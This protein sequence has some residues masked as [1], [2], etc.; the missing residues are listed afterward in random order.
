MS[1]IYSYTTVQPTSEDLLIGTDVGSEKATKS[2]TVGSIAA[3]AGEIASQGTLNSV[4]ISTTNGITAAGNPNGPAVAYTVGLQAGSAPSPETNYFLRGDNTWATPTVTA[5]IQVSNQGVQ[6]TNDVQGLNFAGDG[7]TATPTGNGNVEITIGGLTNTVNSVTAGIGIAATPSNG[8]GDVVIENTGV[9]SLQTGPGLSATVGGVG[10]TTGALLLS[11]TGSSSS[12]TVTSVSAGPGLRISQG[13]ITTSPTLAV[14]YIGTNNIIS[15][16]LSQATPLSTDQIIY[17]QISSGNVKTTTLGQV[18]INALPLVKTYIEDQEVGS[19][20]NTGDTF[21]TAIATNIVTLEQSEYTA[22]ATKLPNTLY[23]TTNTVIAPTETRLQIND[24]NITNNTGV[25]PIPIIIT[26][27]QAYPGTGSTKTGEPG[28]TITPAYNSTI[29]IDENLYQ[30]GG[31]VPSTM[32]NYV[33]VYPA[34][35]NS[36]QLVSSVASTAVLEL[37]TTAP[38]TSTLNTAFTNNFTLDGQPWN[39][40][41]AGLITPDWVQSPT[42]N[43]VITGNN[44]DP[45]DNSTQWGVNYTNNLTTQYSLTAGTDTVVYTPAQGTYDGAGVNV[46]LNGA[47]TTVNS[48]GVFVNIDDQINSNNGADRGTE[49]NILITPNPITGASSGYIVPAGT[50]TISV[51]VQH[52]PFLQVGTSVSFQCTAVGISPFTDTTAFA[53][54]DGGNSTSNISFTP[55]NINQGDIINTENRFTF[56]AAGA[57]SSTQAVSSITSVSFAGLTPNTACPECLTG[58]LPTGVSA[59]F[60]GEYST[61]NGTTWTSPW[62]GITPIP[63]TWSVTV[64]Q[65]TVVKWRWSV[66]AENARAATLLTTESEAVPAVTGNSSFN[67]TFADQISPFYNTGNIGTYEG[68]PAAWTNNKW[69]TGTIVMHEFLPSTLSPVALSSTVAI[70]GTMGEAVDYVPL[71]ITPTGLNTIT[72]ACCDVDLNADIWVLKPGSAAVPIGT[73]VDI[74]QGDTIFSNLEGTT[75]YPDGIYSVINAG[76]R[77]SISTVAGVVQSGPVVCPQCPTNR[78]EGSYSGS[79]ASSTTPYS[80]NALARAAYCA[81]PNTFVSMFI[82]RN[83]TDTNTSDLPSF[84]DQ[85]FTTED[86][87]VTLPAGFYIILGASTLVNA[88]VME[89]NSAGRPGEFFGFTSCP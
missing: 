54:T 55:P 19:I 52:A 42:L 84:N 76:T 61:N 53:I 89:V 1:I 83:P 6:I 10:S 48:S 12:G 31:G 29:S 44:G 59:K 57:M 27:D 3:L 82:E 40:L 28:A 62:D 9:T 21:D 81:P 14:N 11:L 38:S 49:Y 23:F 8:V 30:W 58:T 79:G 5:G 16:G 17:N 4:T 51:Q 73:A 26:G 41:P 56:G 39:S 80:T 66:I 74:A 7:V 78:I 15:S 36:P 13:S 86:G 88:K 85:L 2:F 22:L 32:I 71:G 68:T 60:F 20:K 67:G 18:P 87:N 45:Y 43:P 47:F 24:G 25:S 75:F 46:V 34:A 33:G 63:T 50:S 37:K 72:S 77:S 70:I 69:S 35:G 65:G 64:S